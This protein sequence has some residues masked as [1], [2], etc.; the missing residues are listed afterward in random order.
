ME[1]EATW[2]EKLLKLDP[3][4]VRGFIVTVFA[5][6]GTVLKW[7]VLEGDADLIASGVLSLF[8]LLAAILIRG[9]VTPNVKVIVRDDTPLNSVP[10][11][12]AGEATVPAEY[13]YEVEQAAKQVG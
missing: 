1:Q 5:I 9:G 11:I 4:L 3:A 7:K 13:A 12:E 2:W 8:A 6:A 10:T